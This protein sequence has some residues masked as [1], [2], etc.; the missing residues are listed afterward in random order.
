MT[1]STVLHLGGRFD[2]DGASGL[3]IEVFQTTEF[4]H[5]SLSWT[6]DV[7]I[8]C[9]E[10]DVQSA[11]ERMDD[12]D[13]GPMLADAVSRDTLTS[14]TVLSKLTDSELVEELGGRASAVA[15]QLFGHIAGTSPETE[16]VDEFL[17]YILSDD[18][19]AR[20]VHDAI[21]QEWNDHP[22]QQLLF[23]PKHEGV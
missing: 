17:A 12:D 19:L 4:A 7:E 6:I 10:G 1:I 11:L 5:E 21:I 16:A 18:R 20:R 23:S 2:S 8:E 9:D 13:L 14:E 3:E 15:L 22:D